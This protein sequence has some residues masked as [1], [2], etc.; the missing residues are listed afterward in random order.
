MKKVL[1]F[2]MTCLAMGFWGHLNAQD[3]RELLSAYFTANNIDPDD[4]PMEKMEWRCRYSHNAFYLTDKIPNDAIIHDITELSHVV[5]G[6]HPKKDFVVDLNQLSYYDYD[7]L[8]FQ[9]QNYEHTIYFRLHKGPKRYLAVRKL[10]EMFFRTE[11]PD[12]Y[13]D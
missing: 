10:S 8:Q 2:A 4:Y 7:F 9:H 13:K 3:C 11:Y 6:E 5:T 12:D 1:I